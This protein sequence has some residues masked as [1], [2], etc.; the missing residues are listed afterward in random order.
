MPMADDGPRGNG[1]VLALLASGQ[2]SRFGQ[3]DKLLADLDGMPVIHRAASACRNL[4]LTAKLCVTPPGSRINLEALGFAHMDNPD[5]SEGMAASLRRAAQWAQAQQAGAL[6]VLLADMPF[7][8]SGHL[9][10]ML[11]LHAAQ[12]GKPVFSCTPGGEPMPPA[13][14]PAS[15]FH[16]LAGLTGDRGARHLAKDALMLTCAASEMI[17]IDTE[18][19]LNAA[20]QQA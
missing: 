15:Q 18:E 7:V 5:A 17:D 13:L 2:S 12:P 4:T 10:A 9:Q 8:T 3:A 11:D 1:V 19:E 16:V 6:L 20:R 14:F